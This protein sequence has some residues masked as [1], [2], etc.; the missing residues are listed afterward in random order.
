M[1]HPNKAIY[2]NPPTPAQ[3]LRVVEKS[4]LK[5]AEFERHH[6]LYKDAIRQAVT[7]VSN[8][9]VIHWPLFLEPKKKRSKKQ[10]NGSTGNGHNSSPESA[11]IAP[12]NLPPETPS[13]L[14]SLIEELGL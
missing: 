4:G 12:L 1:T 14:S 9:P 10:S 3:I 13:K 7:G 5:K 11:I 8:I 6:G 2:K